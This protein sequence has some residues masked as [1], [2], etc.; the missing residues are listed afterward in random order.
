MSNFDA[1]IGTILKHEG[2]YSNNPNDT[3]LATK[4]GI[5][6]R[7][8]KT[9][10]IDGDLD[11][12]GDVDPQD[13]KGMPIRIAC[14][15]YKQY[16]WDANDYGSI[17]DQEVA[18]KVFDM[19]V[20]MGAKRAHKIVQ[21]ALNVVNGDALVVDGVIGPITLGKINATDPTELLYALRNQ[22]WEFYVAVIAANP[23]QQVFENGWRNRAFA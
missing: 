21:K 12:D 23:S 22:A 3:G 14:D 6:L 15:L 1:A 10:G 5:S 4:Y 8:L 11:G 7:F 9:L 13:I 2:G 20:N 16:F 17:N 18:T 19:C